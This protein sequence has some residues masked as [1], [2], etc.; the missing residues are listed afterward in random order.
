MLFSFLGGRQKKGILFTVRIKYNDILHIL[1]VRT[2]M[3][4]DY[5]CSY[6]EICPLEKN[7]YLYFFND[8]SWY[9]TFTC[10]C[11]CA[12]TCTGTV[13]CTYKCQKCNI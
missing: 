12:C 8:N 11:T 5:E 1:Y 3:I 2:F 13:P 6:F 7:N 10:A 4:P 9:G